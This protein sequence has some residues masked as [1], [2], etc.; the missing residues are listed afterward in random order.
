MEN[1]ILPPKLKIQKMSEIYI[2]TVHES[3]IYII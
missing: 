1:I 2:H 3:H